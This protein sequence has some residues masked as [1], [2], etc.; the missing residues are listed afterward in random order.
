MWAA[1]G[2]LLIDF[3][4]GVFRSLVTKSFT[5]KLVLGYLSD[6]LHLVFPLLIIMTLMPLD[7]TGWILHAFYY[8]SVLAIIWHYLVEIVNK[9]RA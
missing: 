8:I 9:W 6:L 7:P 5:H 4:I 2:L 3:L 1:T